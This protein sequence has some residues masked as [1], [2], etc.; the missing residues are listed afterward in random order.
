MDVPMVGGGFD[1]TLSAFI[2]NFAGSVFLRLYGKSYTVLVVIIHSNDS[3]FYHQTFFWE[4][5]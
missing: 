3:L 5:K 2:G 4:I 1:K